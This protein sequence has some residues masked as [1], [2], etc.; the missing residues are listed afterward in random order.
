MDEISDSDE[1]P[2]EEATAQNVL[3]EDPIVTARRKSLEPIFAYEFD[4]FRRHVYASFFYRVRLRSILS[5]VRGSD[6][7]TDLDPFIVAAFDKGRTRLDESI[8]RFAKE[9]ANRVCT[10]TH[11]SP[12]SPVSHSAHPTPVLCQ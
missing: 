11:H 9:Y 1:P 7:E 6:P 4:Q 3:R 10:V 5:G 8:E 2:D 12:P